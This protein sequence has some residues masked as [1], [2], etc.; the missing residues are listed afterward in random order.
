VTLFRYY[1]VSVALEKS[2]RVQISFIS[3]GARSIRRKQFGNVLGI[4]WTE[5]ARLT[6]RDFSPRR[7]YDWIRR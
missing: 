4:W 1:N 6:L 5:N 7:I 3:S 2:P